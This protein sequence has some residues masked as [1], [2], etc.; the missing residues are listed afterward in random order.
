MDIKSKGIQHKYIISRTDGKPI[1]E[2]NFY[3]VLKLEGEGDE[4]H[5]EA[6]R[7]AVLKY[8]EEIESHLPELS[9]EIKNR[10]SSKIS[11]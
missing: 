5:I 10:Y 4:K 7:K 9:Q 3:F 1:E 11:I 2:G 8:A 6:C